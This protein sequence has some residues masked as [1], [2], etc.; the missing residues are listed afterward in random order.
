MRSNDLL[1]SPGS[2]TWMPMTA[3]FSGYQHRYALRYD[4]GCESPWRRSSRVFQ[5]RRTVAPSSVTAASL[6]VCCSFLTLLRWCIPTYL[7][8]RSTSYSQRVSIST[9]SMVARLLIVY[10][11]QSPK[12]LTCICTVVSPRLS[13]ALFFDTLCNLTARDSSSKEWPSLIDW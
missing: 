6:M 4:S 13:L 9:V 11:V 3:F 2:S 5:I 1:S 12:S 8:S 10:R 7:R